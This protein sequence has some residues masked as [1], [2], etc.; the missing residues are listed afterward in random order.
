MDILDYQTSAQPVHTQHNIAVADTNMGTD[1]EH[2]LNDKIARFKHLVADYA[3]T[4][5]EKDSQYAEPKEVKNVVQMIAAIDP[6]QQ[7]TNKPTNVLVQT[8]VKKF[9]DDV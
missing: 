1:S 4:F 2:T 9:S 5:M 8:L 7:D 6:K 3:L